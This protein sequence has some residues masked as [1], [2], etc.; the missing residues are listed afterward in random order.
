MLAAIVFD[1]DGVIL[2]SVEIKARAFQRLFA[3]YPEHQERIARLHLEN[4]GMSRY[5]KFQ[6]IY[7]DFLCRPLPE[8]EM[9]RLDREFG[10]IVAE[11]IETCPYVPGAC[12]FLERRARECPL[13]VASG[14]PQGELRAIVERRGLAPLFHGVYGSPR[15]KAVLLQEILAH[16]GAKRETLIFIGDAPQDYHAA[17]EVGVRFIGRIPAGHAN[18][19]PAPAFTLVQDLGELDL[20]WPEVLS[21]IRL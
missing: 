18:P 20:V 5:E 10:R 8:Y 6:R 12:D 15:S 17:Q 16:L 9:V 11:E 2:E 19:F 4:G 7:T 3:G 13:F 21:R 14:T 1:F